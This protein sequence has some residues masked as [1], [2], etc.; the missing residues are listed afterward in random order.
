MRTDSCIP[1]LIFSFLLCTLLSAVAIADSIPRKNTSHLYDLK[2]EQQPVQKPGLLLPSDVAV[3]GRFV[4]VVDGGNHR[5][6]K[7]DL[8][9]NYVDSFGRQGKGPSEFMYPVGIDVASNGWIYIAD[10]GN[11]RI[12]VF[13]SKG[14]YIRQFKVKSGRYLIRPVD[15]LVDEKS[16]ELYVTGNETH[17]VMVFS[18]KGKLKRKWG[19]NGISEGEFRYPATLAHLKDGRI[20]VVDVLNSRVQVFNANGKYST[21]ISAW[22][23][24]AGQVFRPK[25]IAVNKKGNVFISDSYLNLV[26]V[27]EDTGELLHVL[28]MN[29]NHELYTPVGM[30]FDKDDRLYIT[31]MRNNRISV[32]DV[33]P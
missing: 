3:N 29:K 32:F 17:E 8:K 10:S 6:V 16:K 24:T 14:K 23:V 9:G 31:E 25:G 27:F 1:K 28:K 2:A 18:L 22:G 15:V 4:Y 11:K 20:A 5:V 19:G 26:Q 21:Q 30:S 33:T 13:D 7:F 12:Q